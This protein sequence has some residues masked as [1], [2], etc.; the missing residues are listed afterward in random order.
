MEIMRAQH[1]FTFYLAVEK[2]ERFVCAQQ[3]MDR[4]S[5]AE[6]D[7]LIQFWWCDVH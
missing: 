7:S 3:V 6:K 4:K 1:H 2:V 5:W